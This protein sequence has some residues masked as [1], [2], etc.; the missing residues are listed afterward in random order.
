MTTKSISHF[1]LALSLLSLISTGVA[2]S[3]VVSPGDSAHGQ[4]TFTTGGA[5]VTR[6]LFSV[7]E[8]GNGSISGQA[9]FFNN[10]GLNVDIDLNC[11]TIS[12]NTAII[13]GTDKDN[14]STTYAFK[15]TDNGGGSTADRITLPQ[16]NQTCSTFNTL[17]NFAIT[18]G[19]IE[20]RDQ[21]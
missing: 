10:D 17:G 21:P 12:G 6:F 9:R 13:G 15:V 2:R 8:R 20:V 3:T 1:L 16:V 4:G 5:A 7:R 18:T 19:D 11:A 14:P